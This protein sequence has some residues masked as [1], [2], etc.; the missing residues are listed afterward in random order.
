MKKNK[1]GNINVEKKKEFQIDSIDKVKKSSKSIAKNI[2]ITITKYMLIFVILICIYL[3]FLTITGL[4]PS[5]VLEDN[6]RESSETLEQDGEKIIYDLGYKKESIFTFT[7]ALMINTAYS[8]DSNQPFQSVI[9][10]RKNY[11]PGQTRIIYRR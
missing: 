2:L 10:A 8:V 9:L 11:I 1:E 6:V 3:V 4:I 5:S 7:D